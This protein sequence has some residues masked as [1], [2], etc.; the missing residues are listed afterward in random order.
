[1]AR[2]D[3]ITSKKE[4]L[5]FG[6]ASKNANAIVELIILETTFSSIVLEKYNSRDNSNNSIENNSVRINDKVFENINTFF[7]NISYFLLQNYSFGII[8]KRKKLKD[9]L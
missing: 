6:N 4:L 8:Y 1:M 3:N 2:V 7:G 9:F 5:T